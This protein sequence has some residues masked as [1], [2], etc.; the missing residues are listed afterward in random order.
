MSSY[1]STRKQ[2]I[3]PTKM[4]NLRENSKKFKIMLKEKNRNPMTNFKDTRDPVK[5]GN[6]SK[7]MRPIEN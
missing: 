4:R 5:I 2:L 6:P 3:E 7:Q 1:Q